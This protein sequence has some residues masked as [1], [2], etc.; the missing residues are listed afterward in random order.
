MKRED[1]LAELY[2]RRAADISPEGR[3]TLVRWLR[4]K[5]EELSALEL[6]FSWQYP[7]TRYRLGWVR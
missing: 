6:T 1:V 5:A 2:I 3:D 7:K 4:K